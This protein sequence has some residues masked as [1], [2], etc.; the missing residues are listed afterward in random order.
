MFNLF[1]KLFGFGLFEWID[2][3]FLY[4]WWGVVGVL[5]Y[6]LQ[7]SIQD[8]LSINFNIKQLA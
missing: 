6:L 1:W 5:M 2:V 8:T 3:Y 7:D 4:K